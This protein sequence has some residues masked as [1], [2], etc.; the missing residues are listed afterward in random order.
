MA[1]LLLHLL[2]AFAEFEHDSIVE[3]TS[4]GLQ[5]ARRE[6]RIGGR[7]RVIVKRVKIVEMEAEG[8]SLRDI[9]EEIGVSAATVCRIL[10]ARRTGRK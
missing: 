9:A 7:P 3:R 4:A 8:Y 6:G 1:K 5:K 10:P 2:S